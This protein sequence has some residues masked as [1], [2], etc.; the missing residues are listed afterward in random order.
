MDIACKI[1]LSRDVRPILSEQAFS[2]TYTSYWCDTCDLMQTLGEVEAISPDYV[3]LAEEALNENHT[4]IQTQ[5]KQQAFE[6]WFRLFRQHRGSTLE[7]LNVMDIGCGVGGFLD[8]AQAQ[9]AQTFGFDASKVQVER[10]QQSHHQ[11]RFSFSVKEYFEQ[12]AEKPAIDAITM[13]D[14]FEHIRNP[15]EFLTQIREVCNTNSLV[16]VSVPSGAIN[17]LK[18]RLAQLCRTDPGLIPWEHVFYY[19]KKSLPDVF[20]RAG[21]DVLEVGSVATYRRA[22]STHE[23]LRRIGHGLLA[24]TPYSF[25]IYALAR[26]SQTGSAG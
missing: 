7:S 20:K 2:R 21:F 23:M 5:H 4:Y 26:V 1:C 12:L 10:C 18:L 17:P 6:Q 19:T 22:Y 24:S 25:Q 11:V 16:Y 14:V 9:G 8:F 3:D 15:I 13:W